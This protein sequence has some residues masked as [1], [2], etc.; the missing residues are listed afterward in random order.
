VVVYTVFVW[1][2]VERT[3]D[4]APLEAEGVKGWG[5]FELKRSQA[6]RADLDAFRLLAVFMAHWDNKAENQRLVCLDPLP[7]SPD[8]PCAQPLAMMQDV[9]ST[10]GPTKLNLV[11]WR[12]V[13]IWSDRRACTVSMRGFPFRGATFPDATISEEGRT[14]LVAQLSSI[15]DHDL[16]RMFVDARGPEFLSGTNDAQDVAAWR[17]AFHLRV[18]QLRNAGPCPSGR[19]SLARDGPGVD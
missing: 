8:Q 15:G 9:G 5:W 17:E 6:P 19:P 10:F 4:A 12:E 13:P 11:R 1:V 16:E 2:G 3:L 18:E 7:A 14:Q